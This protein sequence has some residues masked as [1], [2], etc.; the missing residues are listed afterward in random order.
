MRISYDQTSDSLYVHLADRASTD[1]DELANGVVL[2]CDTDGVVVGIDMQQAS[3]RTSRNSEAIW[4]V[5]LENEDIL[6]IRLSSKTIV[7]E[8]SPD[9]HTNIG[10][11]ADN[12]IVELLL[13]DAKK[14]G[15]LP[16]VFRNAA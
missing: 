12:S 10:Y 7:R 6:Q 16:L 2:D 9:W 13:L 5:H 14:S 8:V 1:S 3:Q 4:C 15:L 11:A